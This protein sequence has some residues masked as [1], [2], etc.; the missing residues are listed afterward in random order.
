MTHYPS[1]S[2]QSWL[3]LDRARL[4]AGCTRTATRRSCRRLLATRGY[5]ADG[6]GP[7]F[8]RSASR[9]SGDS[10]VTGYRGAPVE[11]SK[12]GCGQAL[13]LNRHLSTSEKARNRS[14]RFG[15]VEPSGG[16]PTAYLPWILPIGSPKHLSRVAL[17]P[18]KP[19]AAIPRKGIAVPTVFPS[20]VLQQLEWKR[21]TP[22]GVSRSPAIRSAPRW[23]E[24]AAGATWTM[25][26]PPCASSRSERPR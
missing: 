9:S 5:R 16:L 2:V 23:M 25:S 18:A 7:H 6:R 10:V 20:G 26:V 8:A 15:L 21:Y 19:C 17:L 3:V 22:F 1:A 14:L 11:R 12:N 24:R 13:P 4:V